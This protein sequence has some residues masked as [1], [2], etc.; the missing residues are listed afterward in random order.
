M[1][2]TGPIKMTDAIKR[3]TDDQDKILQP[4]QTVTMVKKRMNAMELKILDRTL[5]IDNGRLDIPVFF[6]TCGHDAQAVIGTKKQMGKGA[7]TTQAEASAVME[8]AERFSFFSFYTNR[9]HT[10]LGTFNEFADEAISFDQIAK[11]V[12][13]E[14][15]DLAVS[16]KI[17]ESLPLRWTGAWSL[18]REKEVL[19][20]LNWFYAINAFNGPSA[21]NC[22]EEALCQGI[23]EIVERHVSSVIS[24]QHISTP[25][26]DPNSAT[27]HRVR[28]MLGKYDQAGIKLF[29]TDFSQDMGIPSVGVLAYDPATFP[30]TSEIVWTAGTTPSPEK[31]LS[32]A[33]TEV[34]QLAGDFNSGSNYVASG[35]PKFTRLEDAGYVINAPGPISL[36][37]LPDISNPN[38]RHE[39]DACIQALSLRDFEVLAVDTM[40]PQLAVPAF[41]T[42]VPGAHFRERASGTSVAMFAAKITME[43][44]G[45]DEAIKRLTDMERLLPGKYFI[46]F[47]LGN[48]HLGRNDPQTALSRL[49]RALELAPAE[50]DIPSIYS[51]MGVCHKE[52]GNFGKALDV[53][54]KGEVLDPERTDI[55]NLK[56]FCHFMRKEHEA[57]IESFEKVIELDPS[58]AIDYANIASN[59]RDMGEK[60]KAVRY[61]RLALELDPS[62]DFARDNLER[63]TGKAPEKR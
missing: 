46:Q 34:A 54:A 40:H 45:A 31:A 12:H 1:K 3:A 19:V 22:V 60:A 63:L 18:T 7:T 38:I 27:D 21:G 49:A 35:L 14:S 39:V 15:G 8:L 11:S 62:I 26:I 44:F 28:E 2:R 23:C 17:F 48:C 36:V 33:L 25:L 55:H 20:P 61:Y 51:Y 41:Y 32:R 9:N 30:A 24:R 29:I 5:R 53:L 56:G 59:Y 57:A 6:S 16:K 47:Y 43:S 37:N 58:S 10:R 50:Q 52:M 13:D 4:E 42:I